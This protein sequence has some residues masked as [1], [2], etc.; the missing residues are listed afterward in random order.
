MNNGIQRGR[1][2]AS[3][4]ASERSERRTVEGQTQT[5]GRQAPVLIFMR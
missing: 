1:K 3:D 4:R 2:G 5:N